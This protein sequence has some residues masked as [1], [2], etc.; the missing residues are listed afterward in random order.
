MGALRYSLLGAAIALIGAMPAAP[1]LPDDVVAAAAAVPIQDGGRVKP[2]DTYARFSLLQL[3]GRSVLR[4]ESG[5]TIEAMPWLL[6]CLFDPATAGTRDVFLIENPEVMEALH[7][8]HATPRERFAYA[9][10]TPARPILFNL[11]RQYGALPSES[12]TAAQK[13]TLQ[14]ASNLRLFEAI[15]HAITALARNPD[16]PSLSDLLA[17]NAGGDDEQRTRQLALRFVAL[18]R[19]S[20][21]A[22][23][24]PDPASNTPAE[25]KTP[26][27]LV[28]DALA[29]KPPAAA[30]LE[31]L[32]ALEHLAN[33]GLNAETAIA[34]FESMKQAAARVMRGDRSFAQLPR[35]LFF[36][37]LQ[38][39]YWSL[40]L[41]GV[42]FLLVACGWILPRQRL[43]Y[44]LGVLS[45]C[46]PLGL[47]I[48]GIALRCV[49]RGRPPVSTLYE[50]I[51]FVTAVAVVVA[52][53]VEIINRRR[54]ALGLGAF[55]GALG[56]FLAARYEAIDRSDTMPNLIAVLDTNFWLS[57][58]VT[59]VTM[60]YAAGLLAGAVAHVFLLGKT[61]GS[62]RQ[63]PVFYAHLSRMVYG[64]FC[65]GL[66]FA[67][68]GT[69]LGG[70]WANESW[71]RFWGWDPK[72][73][74]AL[75]IVLWGLAVL[76]A[77]IGGYIQDYGLNMAAVFGGIVVAYSWFG[78]NLLG[79]GL[80]S[81]GFTSGIQTALT[82]FYRV[83]SIVLTIAAIGWLREQGIIRIVLK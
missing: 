31:V 19:A 63:D 23:I 33:T 30:Q 51:L 8:D 16:L 53:V 14:L 61:L 4:S 32:R 26:K 41:Y 25:W 15:T 5:D 69:V 58:H 66:L 62:R 64:I 28:Q 81:Y 37:R 3:S 39:F 38:P 10:L 47:H 67:T 18:E 35:E 6:E 17:G 68:V 44:G 83:E 20:A 57:T 27:A 36:Y 71:G 59:T 55:L 80:H 34:D 74:G 72:E 60:G 12:R 2:L 52:L 1:S 75:M 73:N 7:L 40:V 77:R 65:F 11:A 22:M 56:L 46:L 54:V 78:V 45:L 49:I 21:L 43:L 82:Q 50:T 76:H 48:L 79:V 42:A 9:A 24:P 70:I 13:Q 29:G